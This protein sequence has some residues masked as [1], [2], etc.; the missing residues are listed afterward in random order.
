M[1]EKRPTPKSLFRGEGEKKKL[2]GGK[3]IGSLRRAISITY[4]YMSQERIGRLLYVAACLTI[5]C[6]ISV[7]WL[8]PYSPTTALEEIGSEEEDVEADRKRLESRGN[9]KNRT[10]STYN[11]TLEDEKEQR[12]QKERDAQIE[13]NWASDTTRSMSRVAEDDVASTD[14]KEDGK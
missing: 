11:D 5:V 2:E 14:N 13:E 6:F 1:R 9:A 3:E 12:L 8:D 10:N 7:H 4:S